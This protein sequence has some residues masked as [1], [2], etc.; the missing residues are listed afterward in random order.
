MLEESFS[1][2][3]GMPRTVIMYR[4]RLGTVKRGLDYEEIYQHCGVSFIIILE[5]H[6]S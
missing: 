2:G 3:G 4:I 5:S 1:P 6:L